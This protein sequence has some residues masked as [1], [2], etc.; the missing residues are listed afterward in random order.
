MIYILCYIYEACNS[1]FFFF[2]ENVLCLLGEYSFR[3]E[4]ERYVSMKFILLP[5]QEF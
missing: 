5:R 4:K 2:V 1:C 3:K